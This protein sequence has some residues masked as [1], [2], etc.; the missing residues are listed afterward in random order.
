MIK[1]AAREKRTSLR[2]AM[3][4]VIHIALGA[5]RL[6][7][8][9]LLSWWSGLLP[10]E[11]SKTFPV[12]SRRG[13]FWVPMV[14][15]GIPGEKPM[16]WSRF[17]QALLRPTVTGVDGGLYRDLLYTV[18]LLLPCSGLQRD[19]SD[20]HCHAMCRQPVLYPQRTKYGA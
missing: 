9:I 15:P 10:C 3:P 7:G 8:K 20:M 14:S 13:H 2:Q 5:M 17:R 4:V 18:S 11:S 12:R 19:G 16:A 6:S 1:Q